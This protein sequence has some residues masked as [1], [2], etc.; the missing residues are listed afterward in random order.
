[1]NNLKN[2]YLSLKSKKLFFVK[3]LYR[4]IAFE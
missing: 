1:M 3:H 2:D 4:R